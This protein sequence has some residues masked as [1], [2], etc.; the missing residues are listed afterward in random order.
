MGKKSATSPQTRHVLPSIQPEV[1]VAHN[2]WQQ[3]YLTNRAENR[4]KNKASK[5]RDVFAFRYSLLAQNWLID[6]YLEMVLILC[7]AT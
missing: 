2:G 5:L 6:A 3:P 7:S 1:R 4:E